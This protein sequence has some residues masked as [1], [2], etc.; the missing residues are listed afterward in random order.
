MNYLYGPVTSR[1]LGSSLGVDIL[2]LKTCSFNCIY[3]Q[4][5][6]TTRLTLQRREYTPVKPVLAEIEQY[7]AG[8]GQRPD[9]ITFSGSGEP[10]LHSKLGELIRGVKGI[11]GAKVAV[12]TN[13]SLLALPE[14]R[15][16][17]LPADL[18]VP[19]LDAATQPVFERVN[20]PA[21]GLRIDSIIDSLTAFRKEFSAEL[22]LEILL[23][24][25][26][27]D[28]EAELNA[29]KQAAEK[30]APDSIDLNTPVRPPAEESAKTLAPGR[31]REIA[32][33]LG[34]NASAVAPS[35][36]AHRAVPGE[37]AEKILALLKRRPCSF[38][39]LCS[40]LGLETD[41]AAAA[42]AAL[43]RKGFVTSLDKGRDGF[44][45]AR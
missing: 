32:G 14:V 30:I 24:K 33:F 8:P 37:A 36:K 44:Y 42:L 15:E 17:L 28:T 1:R 41:E 34:P 40:S 13:S 35:T 27:N 25:G 10:T 31:L 20:R 19:S 29:I 26:I 3:C 38:A 18:V 7:L 39:E 12:L 16:E 6:R 23:V 43:S 11:T 5:G 4:L 2:P 9:Y 21:R 45:R 22:R